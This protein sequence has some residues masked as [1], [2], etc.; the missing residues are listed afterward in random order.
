M[1]FKQSVK[2]AHIIAQAADNKQ[3]DNILAIDV[4][5]HTPFTDVLVIASAD[6]ERKVKAICDEIEMLMKDNG[7]NTKR[8]E[9]QDRY[10]WVVLDFGGVIAHIFHEEAR[11]YFMLEKLWKDCPTIDISTAIGR[12][13]AHHE[14][15]E[16]GTSATLPSHD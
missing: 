11:E 8:S 2:Y 1:D 16:V 15:Q 5:E 4:H 7:R 9:G 12:T 3:A 13:Q 14:T 10:H 6:N